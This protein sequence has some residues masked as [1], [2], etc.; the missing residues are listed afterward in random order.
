MKEKQVFNNVSFLTKINPKR[1]VLY[2][3]GV[4]SFFFVTAPLVVQIEVN[5]TAYL[6]ILLSLLSF[7]L[8]G[9][10]TRS[11]SIRIKTVPISQI[12]V[13]HLFKLILVLAIFGLLL[14]T[15]DRF[16]V[17]G[18]TIE[19]DYFANRDIMEKGGGNP[20]AILAA[21][22][23]P[24]GL[25]PLFIF[26]KYKLKIN[27]LVKILVYLVFF[28]HFFDAL[29]IGS[30]SSIFVTVVFFTLFVFFFKK[31][32]LTIRKTLILITISLSFLFL[33]N[34]IF[35]ERTK[36][37]AGDKAIEV[38]LSQSN[39]NYTLT[40][41]KNFKE[42][43]N[44]LNPFLQTTAFTYI[45]T[46]QYFTHGMIEFSYLYDNFTKNHA[47]GQ[48]TFD[49]YFRFLSKF[50]GE[51]LNKEEL[52]NL[53]PR[54]GV[55]TTFFG[56]VFIDF[57]WFTI[58]FMFFFGRFTYIIFEKAK[59]GSDWSTLMYFFLFIILMFSPVFN[60]IN[61][62]GGIFIF[63]NILLFH[64]ITKKFYHEKTY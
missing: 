58:L 23:V 34:Y 59:Q 27:L 57:G 9:I 37:F 14:K 22:F 50:T 6:L 21:F 48:Y 16:F 47:L 18:I 45:T 28:G 13:Y 36:L 32:V 33:M 38:V 7:F 2:A 1:T 30:R 63:T 3:F 53:P 54:D 20:I 43:F 24:F 29:L 10:F 35:L 11:K 40:S 56:P 41:N 39:F 15:I 4:W 19:S 46:I 25:I 17:R 64:I 60:F 44:S 42:N 5:Y 52:E 31:F 62:A 61:G 49:V 8:G 26:W 12:K 51:T 55:Y